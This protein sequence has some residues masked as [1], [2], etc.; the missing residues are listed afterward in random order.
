[1]QKSI[2]N[3]TAKFKIKM[4]LLLPCFLL[5]QAPMWLAQITATHLV[6]I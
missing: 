1:M 4:R 5:P 2:M 6:F 3:K